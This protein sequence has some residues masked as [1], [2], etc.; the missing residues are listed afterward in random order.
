MKR[1]HFIA[2]SATAVLGWTAARPARAG[3]SPARKDLIELRTYHFAS[4]AKQRAFEAF[5]ADCAIPALNR[6][7]VKPV[8]VF[9]LLKA[10][11]PKLKLETDSTDLRVVLRHSSMESVLTLTAR[12]A[13]DADFTA[14]G[15]DILTAPKDD[16]AYTRFESS[17]MLAFDGQPRVEV[18]PLAPTRVLQLRTYESHNDERALKKIAMFNT[19]GELA[20]FR[21]CGMPPVFFGQS[22]IGDKLPNLTYMLSFENPEA[23]KRG[24][25]RFGKDPGWQSLRRD[26]AYQDTVSRITNLILRP[27]RGSQI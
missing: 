12:L 4:P 23:L 24:W 17:L 3:L 1:R 15:A 8:G 16:P 25:G 20:I 2:T 13:G 26:P 27:A 18:P 19:G 21:R 11:N 7:G 6:A 9:K 22:L 10:D 5:L 14:A